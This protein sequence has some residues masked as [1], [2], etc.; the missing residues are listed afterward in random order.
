MNITYICIYV[1]IYTVLGTLFSFVGGSRG[2][3]L[4]EHGFRRRG[5]RG[6]WPPI[7]FVSLTW[8]MRFLIQL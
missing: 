8:G 2:L 4:E 5:K 3:V 7:F 1:C 6:S